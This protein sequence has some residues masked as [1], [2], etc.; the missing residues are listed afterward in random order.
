MP[1][2]LSVPSR[3]YFNPA[4]NEFFTTKQCIVSLEHS[5][6]SISRWES[7]WHKAYLSQNDKTEEEARD[8][9]R[10][11]LIAP[12]A[13]KNVLRALTE[14]PSLLKKIIEYIQD[15]MSATVINDK[16]KKVS[17]E[18]VTNEL[19]YCWMVSLKIP[20]EPCE[21]WHLNHLM[22]LIEVCAVKNTPPKKMSKSALMKRNTALNAKRRAMHH[23]TG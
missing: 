5:L 6:I 11:M 4:T 8:Y 19:I 21:K 20:F 22:K 17:R 7:K 9:I 12:V 10:C 15:P 18:V 23:N 1:L 13:D 3:E 14:D 16:G 2:V